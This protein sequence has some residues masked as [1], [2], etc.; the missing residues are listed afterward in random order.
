MIVN[1]WP[2]IVATLWSWLGSQTSSL[3]ILLRAFYR[4]EGLKISGTNWKS[5]IIKATSFASLICKKKFMFYD[6]VI[7]ILLN[8]SLHLRKCDM[9]LI[10]LCIFLLAPAL[11][12]VCVIF[13][14]PLRPNVTM[15]KL[16]DS[17]KV[18]MNNM[19]WFACRLCLCNLSLTL[20]RCFRCWS[21]KSDDTSIQLNH[22]SSMINSTNFSLNIEPFILISSLQ[23]MVEVKV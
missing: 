14:P 17:S 15:I 21:N 18:L 16:F 22:T 2:R 11:F 8:T 3:L 13:F 7:F 19:R 9:N 23:A 6:N 10:T 5:V 20:T 4:W 1:P 12:P